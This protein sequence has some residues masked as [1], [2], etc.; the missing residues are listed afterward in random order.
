[1][2]CLQCGAEITEPSQTYCHICGA[3]IEN[4]F[5]GQQQQQDHGFNRNTNYADPQYSQDPHIIPR[6]D[7]SPEPYQQQSYRYDPPPQGQYNTYDQYKRGAQ[8]S[9]PFGGQPGQPG[10]GFFGG[11]G[12][13][14]GGQPYGQQYGQPYGQQYQQA[15]GNQQFGGTNIYNT[16]NNYSGYPARMDGFSIK[17]RWV[18][19][20]LCCLGFMGVGGIHRL[21]CGKIATGLLWLFTFGFFGIGTVID[22]ILL[23]TGN[24]RD[25]QGRF[26]R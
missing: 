14:G 6:P 1:M 2:L 9:N 10:A 25:N 7:N 26:L 5:P 13:M 12:G 24:W 15:M 19:T 23:I 16:Y 18:A 8:Y 4:P 20:G 21:Y 17:N 11:Q 22:L 3:R